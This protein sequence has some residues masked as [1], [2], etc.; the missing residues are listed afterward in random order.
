MR[1]YRGHI[2]A[3]YLEITGPLEVASLEDALRRAVAETDTLNVG[4]TE[5]D[6]GPRQVYAPVPDWPF[7][8]LDVSGEPDPRAAA[9]AWMR[10]EVARPVSLESGRTFV[11][12]LLRTGDDRH[13]L[14]L[15]GHHLVTDGYM[16]ALFAHRVAEEV[17]AALMVLM[18]AA[19]LVTHTTTL[20]ALALPLHP[21]HGRRL[22]RRR[23]A[24]RAASGGVP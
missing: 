3:E 19:L 14:Y 13:V 2:A 4:F 5:G 9:E 15:R 21:G 23:G 12:A 10:A 6:D 1:Q 20:D 16:C 22:H 17:L 24:G 18:A 11:L 8:V 7:P